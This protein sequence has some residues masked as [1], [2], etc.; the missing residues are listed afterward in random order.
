MVATA[1]AKGREREEE[2]EGRGD[3]DAPAPADEDVKFGESSSSLFPD[4]DESEAT[5]D[6][7]SEGAK[8]PVDVDITPLPRSRGEARL[9]RA[10]AAAAAAV[11]FNIVG[12]YEA[13]VQVRSLASPLGRATLDFT[14]AAARSRVSSAMTEGRNARFSFSLDERESKRP[15]VARSASSFVIS[16]P[17]DLSFFLSLEKKERE[18]TL[19]FLFP[20]C[21]PTTSYAPGGLFPPKSCGSIDPVH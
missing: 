10:E 3:G 14:R 5:P 16:R 12:D 4:D 19:L 17:L 15:T 18:A 7:D 8:P 1:G 11:A 9:A 13:M 6:D 2:E 21:A 20:A